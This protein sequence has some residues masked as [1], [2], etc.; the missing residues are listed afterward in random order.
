MQVSWQKHFRHPRRL[1]NAS[2][3]GKTSATKTATAFTHATAII[4]LIKRESFTCE[5]LASPRV[6]QSLDHDQVSVLSIHR[7]FINQNF[8][9]CSIKTLI[10]RRN[11]HRVNFTRDLIK[12]SPS[13]SLVSNC[14][15]EFLSGLFLKV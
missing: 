2:K 7:R 9:Y 10:C 6:I 14:V 4:A 11:F 13:R 15:T 5:I 3:S 12:I 8:K 1:H